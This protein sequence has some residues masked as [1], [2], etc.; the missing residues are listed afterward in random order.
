MF[1]DDLAI[2]LAGSTEKRLSVNIIELEKR[3][4]LAMKQLET[5]SNNAIL[6]VNVAK[7][8]AL[9]V[10]GAVAPQLPNVKYKQ[11][12]IE[13]VTSFKYLGVYWC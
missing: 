12:K 10:H 2:V 5:F 4:E 7:T 3:A 11:E 1:A 6:P 9:L 8:K 13:Y